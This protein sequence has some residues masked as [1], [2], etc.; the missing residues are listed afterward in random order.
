MEWNWAGG[1]CKGWWG[2]SKESGQKALPTARLNASSDT[3][4]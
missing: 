3:R 4:A 2:K 1:Q